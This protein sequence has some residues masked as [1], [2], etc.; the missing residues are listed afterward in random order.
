MYA[1]EAM[2][3]GPKKL[4]IPRRFD[5]GSGEPDSA[6]A[7]NVEPFPDASRIGELAGIF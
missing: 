4:H 2:N 1:I 7:L 6:G 5:A 3:A